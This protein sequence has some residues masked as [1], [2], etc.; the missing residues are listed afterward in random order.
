MSAA[1][2]RYVSSLAEQHGARVE[3]T[4]GNHLRVRHPSGWFAVLPSTP[5]DHRARQNARATVRRAMRGA[6]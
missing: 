2:F 5:S 1:W 6:G 3:V 4:N